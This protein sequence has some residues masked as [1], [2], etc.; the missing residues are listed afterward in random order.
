MSASADKD[1]G[2]TLLLHICLCP[3]GLCKDLETQQGQCHPHP[4][5]LLTKL[6]LP[7]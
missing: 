7:R 6:L 4:S 5:S 3:V 1:A 2:S